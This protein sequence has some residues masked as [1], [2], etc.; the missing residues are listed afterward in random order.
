M[1]K[2][3]CH[4]SSVTLRVCVAGL[5]DHRLPGTAELVDHAR[6]SLRRHL[7]PADDHPCAVRG[8]LA[9]GGQPQAAGT[10]GDDVH[11]VLQTEVHLRS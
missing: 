7:Q 6:R 2:L 8:Q 11:A 9:C 1:S 3:D 4:C 10:A 5:H